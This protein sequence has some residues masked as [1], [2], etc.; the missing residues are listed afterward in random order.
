MF[1]IPFNFPFR[2]KDGSLITIDDAISSG[3]GGG[4]TLPTASAET[5]G[6]VK[7]GS[8]LSM[9]GEVLNNANPT[10]Y[11]L[12][13]ASGE[14]LGG[15]KIGDG[16]SI[17]DGVVKNTALSSIYNITLETGVSG[18]IKA[19]KNDKGFIEISGAVTL[20]TAMTS[21]RVKLASNIDPDLIAGTT[22]YQWSAL[23][24]VGVTASFE[25]KIV[26]VRFYGS[27]NVWLQPETSSTPIKYVLINGVYRND[28][29]VDTNV[30]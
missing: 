20:E 1:P 17:T 18:F 30:E 15:V 3:G 26:D 11:S 25:P 9:S 7:I 14:V 10:P 24:A 2:K 6:G 12:P 8:G 22:G 29:Y 21:A 4:Y 23:W 16:L 19:V 28:V 27:G 13:T 5:K